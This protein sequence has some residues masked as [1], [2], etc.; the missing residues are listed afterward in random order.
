[1]KVTA[2]DG[3]NME[4]KP[5]PVDVAIS[6]RSAKRRPAATT[7]LDKAVEVLAGAAGGERAV[8]TDAFVSHRIDRAAPMRFRA[9]GCSPRVSRAARPCSS[10]PDGNL[11]GADRQAAAIRQIAERT[12]SPAEPHARGF[13][14]AGAPTLSTT[15]VPWTLAGRTD[16]IPGRRTTNSNPMAWLAL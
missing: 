15:R 13:R 10:L 9:L 1:M 5:R 14:R 16:T 4:L 2:T 12:G 8:G 11:E 7:Q 6:G 3:T